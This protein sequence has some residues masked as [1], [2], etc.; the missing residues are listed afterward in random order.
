MISPQWVWWVAHIALGTTLGLVYLLFGRWR[1]AAPAPHRLQ[2]VREPHLHKAREYRDEPPEPPV[3]RAVRALFRAPS[4]RQAAE[5]PLA[6]VA[7]EARQ[8]AVHKLDHP[9]R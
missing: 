8:S 1:L 6:T 5:L 2:D 3:R 4:S 9:Q 7:I